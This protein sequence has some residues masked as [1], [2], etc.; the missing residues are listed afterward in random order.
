MEAGDRSAGDG[1]EK[2][3]EDPWGARRGIGSDPCHRRDDLK[4]LLFRSTP[5]TEQSGNNES[6]DD[7]PA[8]TEDGELLYFR[9]VRASPK[10]QIYRLPF[11]GGAVETV[12][13]PPCV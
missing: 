7:Q 9:T 11:N 4:C 1:D 13:E 10:P 3:W 8:I 12:T 5:E 2:E 6:D